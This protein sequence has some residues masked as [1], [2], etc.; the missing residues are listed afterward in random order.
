MQSGHDLAAH[1]LRTWKVV[2][3]LVQLILI[4]RIRN[5]DANVRRFVQPL[6][7]DM[8]SQMLQPEA[9]ETQG[10]H[11]SIVFMRGPLVASNELRQIRSDSLQTLKE[12]YSEAT[13]DE[14]RKKVVEVMLAATRL[15][16]QGQY[17]VELLD[18]VLCDASDIVDFFVGQFDNLGYELLQEIE[19]DIFVL[20]R[21]YH[22]LSPHLEV[23]DHTRQSQQRLIDS[24]VA[25]RDHANANREFVIYKT[26][27]GYKSVFPPAWEND[28][29][30]FR[31]EDEYRHQRIREL[32]A[33]VAPDNSEDWLRILVRCARV[34]SDDLATFPFFSEFLTELGRVHP[35]V[36]IGYLASLD[37]NLAQ[38]LPAMLRGIE[39]G[40]RQDEF[41]GMI[42]QWLADKLYLPQIAFHLRNTNN[43]RPETLG[44]CLV[45]GI[46]A[47]N[48]IAVLGVLDAAVQRHISGATGLLET[49]ILPGVA[50]LC[51]TGDLRWTGVMWLW[52]KRNM[53]AR[54]L[55]EEQLVT[56]LDC[57]VAAPKIDPQ[58]ETII[59]CIAIQRPEKVV[60]FFVKRLARQADHPNTVDYEA[61]PFDLLCLRDALGT[62]PEYFLG[63]IRSLFKP[64][65]TLFPYRAGQL[66]SA[67]FPTLTPELEAILFQHLQHGQDDICFVTRILDSY[68]FG[69]DSLHNVCKQIITV[70]PDDDP[71][72]THVD[73]ILGRGGSPPGHLVWRR[74]SRAHDHSLSHGVRMRTKK[75]AYSRNAISNPLI[76][77]LRTSTVALKRGSR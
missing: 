49:V 14:G 61:V 31:A 6:V 23:D 74:R 12:L 50:H 45:T 55:T 59:T 65:D 24:I 58:V 27:V 18:V 17:T 26:L 33:E 22:T 57:L 71:L 28:D 51:S 1:S 5:L 44:Q 37:E 75:F 62:I 69:G 10:Q 42:Q 68:H 76:A 16:F 41:S 48:S 20:H 39:E 40:G 11:D 15:P 4:Q 46:A 64:D 29:F 66:V 32:A 63:Q 13:D 43:F 7:M 25:F 3:P 2:G 9:T 53:L 54:D 72:L 67:V 34:K 73:I 47:K 36:V 35:E 21:T 19:H 52:A 30:A 77:R 60:D 56:L 8:V 38:F 70:L